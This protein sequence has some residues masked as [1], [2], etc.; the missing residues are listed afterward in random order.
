MT[1]SDETKSISLVN[2]NLLVNGQSVAAQLKNINRN[3]E[4]LLKINM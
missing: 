2:N 4:I 1:S 3:I